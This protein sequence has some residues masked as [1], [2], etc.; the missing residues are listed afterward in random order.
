MGMRP[1]FWVPVSA[2]AIV[3][4]APAWAA[5]EIAAWPVKPTAPQLS[6][7]QLAAPPLKSRVPQ[8]NKTQRTRTS[9]N[10]LRAARTIAQA[11]RQP[12]P[13]VIVHAVPV[14]ASRSAPKRKTVKRVARRKVH[15]AARHVRARRPGNAFPPAPK[16]AE[17]SRPVFLDEVYVQR[18]GVPLYG[19]YSKNQVVGRL[20]AATLVTHMGR[21]GNWV[22][23]EAPNGVVGYVAARNIGP[24]PPTW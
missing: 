8:R 19:I 9:L 20:P 11:L 15:Y 16:P 12:D 2:L 7:P 4:G 23:V 17:V 13:P 6:R 10:A 3:F 22:K 5:S 14:K 1:F 21:Q 24:T 18:P